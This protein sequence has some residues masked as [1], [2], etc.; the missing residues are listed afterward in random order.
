MIPLIDTENEDI[1]RSCWVQHWSIKFETLR[2]IRV[3][4]QS[5][6]QSSLLRPKS[7]SQTS[8]EAPLL[9]GCAD[10]MGVDNKEKEK[11]Q[12][13]K[14]RRDRKWGTG[15]EEKREKERE[16]GQS[17]YPT[18][19]ERHRATSGLPALPQETVG[20]KRAQQ[21]QRCETC[22]R[23]QLAARKEEAVRMRNHLL[24]IFHQRI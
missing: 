19:Q 2:G 1:G 3:K 15:Q 21:K 24:A 23:G 6:M 13:I 14:E 5:E 18:L 4:I 17:L 22:H 20:G 8:M 7:K 12:V 10:I 11:K 16:K 9:I